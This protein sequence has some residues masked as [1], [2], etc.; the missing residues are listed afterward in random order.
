[1][2]APL[3]QA[4]IDQHNVPVLC[5]AE[6]QEITQK[7][8]HVLLFFT[9][10]MKPLPETADVAVILPELMRAFDQRF[11]V[12]VVSPGDQRMLQGRYRFRKYPALVMLRD[13]EYCG[14]M[15]GV[16][17]WPDYLAELEA[18]LAA[19]PC[20]PPPFFNNTAPGAGATA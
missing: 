7:H 14:A 15:T 2:F 4:L 20:E 1:M 19:E 5:D 10:I 16:K 3:V 17:D 6:I 8:E 18:L 9:D 12:A 11:K 13:G